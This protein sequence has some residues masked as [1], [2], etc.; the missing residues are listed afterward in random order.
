MV[1][2]LRLHRRA[3]LAPFRFDPPPTLL[4][5]AKRPLFWRLSHDRWYSHLTAIGTHLSSA[6]VC[7]GTHRLAKLSASPKTGAAGVGAVCR[8]R[9]ERARRVT[10]RGDR[11]TAGPGKKLKEAL[12][13]GELSSAQKKKR[14]PHAKRLEQLEQQSTLLRPLHRGRC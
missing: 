1:Q 13:S 7:C 10:A 5:Q 6:C 4:F 12:T 14:S 3:A 2:D 11:Q 9:A 8:T